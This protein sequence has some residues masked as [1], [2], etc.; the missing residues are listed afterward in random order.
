MSQA[1]NKTKSPFSF[2]SSIGDIGL[3]EQL[4]PEKGEKGDGEEGGRQRAGWFTLGGEVKEGLYEGIML[5]RNLNE[6]QCE[7]CELQ[8]E[9]NSV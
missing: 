8:S 2:H 1:V 6:A 3:N 9:P 7:L 5:E 4:K